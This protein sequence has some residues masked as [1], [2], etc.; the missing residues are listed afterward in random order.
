MCING[1]EMVESCRD[2]RDE[3]CVQGVLGNEPTGTYEAFGVKGDYIEA[4]CRKNRWEDCIGIG[5]KKA[6]ENVAYR[7]CYWAPFGIGEGGVCIPEVPPGL[8]FWVDDRVEPIESST[9]VSGGAVTTQGTAALG[10]RGYSVGRGAEVCEAGSF[11]CTAVFKRGGVDRIMGGD[12][13][14]CV[15]NCHC[16]MKDW[17]VAANNFCKSLGDCGAY[18]NI[19]GRSTMDGFTNSVSNLRLGNKYVL[20]KIDLDN[21]D[22]LSKPGKKGYE[23]PGFFSEITKNK[24]GLAT[25]IGGGLYGWIV[26]PEGVNFIEGFKTGA[27]GG[28]GALGKGIKGLFGK[29]EGTFMKGWSKSI[30]EAYGGGLRGIKK[31][32]SVSE[33]GL[34]RGDILKL[35]KNSM[36]E[37]TTQNE[38]IAGNYRIIGI[39]DSTNSIIVKQIGENGQLVGDK[40]FIEQQQVFL[41]DAEM[42]SQAGTGSTVMGIINTIGWIYTIY[43]LVDVLFAETEEVTYTVG[44]GLWQAPDGGSDCE[45]CNEGDKPCSLYRCKSLG[46]LCSLVNPGTA[47]EKCVNIHPNDV[48]S[49][50]I[51]PDP[52]KLTKGYTLSETTIESNKGFEINEKLE[53]FS[54]ISFGI[55]TDEVSQ[56]KFSKDPG[57]KYDEM[58]FFFGDQIYR[59]EHGISFSFPAELTSREA[60]QL[61]NGGEYMLYIRCKDASG[62]VND[63]D[64]FIKFNIKPS[65][66]LT[67]PVIEDTSIDNG[68]YLA[69]GTNETELIL[70]LNEPAQCKWDRN[71][72]DYS[73]MIHDFDCDRSGFVRANK[74]YQ[75]KT[76]LTDLMEENIFYFKCRDLKGNTN[77]ESYE[78]RLY[79]SDSLFITSAGPSGVFYVPEQTLRVITSGGAEN[80]KAKCGYFE[81]DVSYEDMIEFLETDS[82]SHQQ[83]LNLVKGIYAYYVKCRDIAGNEDSTTISFEIDVDFDSPEIVYVYKEGDTL[84][85]EMNEVSSCRYLT[86][87]TFF[88][89]EEGLIMTGDGSF[90]HEL[91]STEKMFNVI[92]V[93][94][95]GNEGGYKIYV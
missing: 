15:H 69:S 28:L 94:E 67:A 66:D 70:F 44:C 12:D 30:T 35:S 73:F 56:C 1:E 45:K 58:D 65:P 39:Q 88:S 61:T 18:Y 6:C 19:L 26:A 34:K 57:K 72:R 75:C 82:I 46:Q 49:P 81:E 60:L 22:A 64:Y 59:Y 21:W 84:Y 31:G 25:I 24:F 86:N 37:Q 80:G 38:L 54:M 48:N 55:K 20:T 5:D 2:F 53:P 8:K 74:Y 43:N 76:T 89:Y 10:G 27:F 77:V 83:P 95:Y 92:C 71:D 79:G 51:S 68:G 32:M 36:I 50:R 42:V 4:A 14:E 93:D 17:I 47:D 63:R 23:A 11:E 91:Q 29:G 41:K 85:L 16:T 7:D 52:G 40:I 90:V 62:N 13:W 9:R 33:V 87:S 3:I 78:F